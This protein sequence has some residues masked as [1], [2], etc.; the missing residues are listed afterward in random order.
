MMNNLGGM[1]KKVQQMQQK[2]TELGE[3]MEARQ[4]SASV[5]GGSVTAEVN[6]KG[7]VLSVSIAAEMMVQDE[8]EMLEELVVLAVNSAKSEAEA[9]QQ[10]AIKEITGGL[11]LPPGL[12]LPF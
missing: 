12:S 9:A 11:P 5:G 4:F 3:E 7:T 8:R 2:L 6:G 1:M 10:Q